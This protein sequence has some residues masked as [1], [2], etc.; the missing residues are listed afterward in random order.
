MRCKNATP[1]NRGLNLAKC[2]LPS[3]TATIRTHQKLTPWM[4]WA[5]KGHMV[6]PLDRFLYLSWLYL[7]CSNTRMT[8][9]TSG[10]NHTALHACTQQAGEIYTQTLLTAVHLEGSFS[11]Q[12]EYKQTC[13]LWNIF[14]QFLICCTYRTVPRLNVHYTSIIAECLLCS[15][16]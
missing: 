7:V 10:I 3:A 5:L 1:C 8:R 14:C 11:S 15:I 6:L 13:I 16:P 9:G 2:S 4:F 12:P